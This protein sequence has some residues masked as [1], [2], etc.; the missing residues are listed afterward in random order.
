MIQE[1]NNAKKRNTPYSKVD[2]QD[3]QLK[4]SINRCYFI[5]IDLR[6]VKSGLQIIENAHKLCV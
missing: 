3:Y 6:R 5:G 2:D 1:L 4:S